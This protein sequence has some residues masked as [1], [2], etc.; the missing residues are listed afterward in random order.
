[1]FCPFSSTFVNSHVFNLFTF[2]NSHPFDPL[3]SHSLGK[4]EEEFEKK[5]NSLPQYSPL[6]FDKKNTSVAKKKKPC[7]TILTDQVKPTK[8]EPKVFVGLFTDLSSSILSSTHFLF[9]LCLNV[10]A[11]ALWHDGHFTYQAVFPFSVL[12][13]PCNLPGLFPF[14]LLF[15]IL[16]SSASQKKTLF[17]KIVSKY[18]HKK[19]KP[20][21]LDKGELVLPCPVLS[22]HVVLCCHAFYF[23]SGVNMRG[24]W[25]R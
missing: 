1:M 8:G 9:T 17:H 25:R 20:N 6:T 10:H 5:F 16:G 21:T 22:C 19:E 23:T 3:I 18:K 2:Y 24:F 12:F 11:A 4:L 15:L 13:L 14:C 7:S